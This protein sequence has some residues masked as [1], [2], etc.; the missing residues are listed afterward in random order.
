[1]GPTVAPLCI[2]S[3]PFLCVRFIFIVN[4]MTVTAILFLL[5]KFEACRAQLEL[6]AFASGYGVELS[7]V[8]GADDI[9]L[10]LTD[11]L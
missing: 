2:T 7:S 10:A 5:E 11:C 9:I 6:L 1:M 8:V 4:S 3:Y